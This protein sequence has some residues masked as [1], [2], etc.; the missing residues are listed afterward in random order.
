MLT[1]A[2]HAKV[3]R[4]MR[5]SCRVSHHVRQSHGLQRAL[6]KAT[7]CQQLGLPLKGIRAS[8]HNH[9]QHMMYQLQRPHDLKHSRNLDRH[10]NIYSGRTSASTRST[11]LPDF[12]WS[13]LIWSVF[14]QALEVGFSSWRYIAHRQAV[15]VLAAST[16]LDHQRFRVLS[17]GMEAFVSWAR[18]GFLRRRA[19]TSVPPDWHC[20]SKNPQVEQMQR[21]VRTSFVL[22]LSLLHPFQSRNCP[23]GSWP[24]MPLTHQACLDFQLSQNIETTSTLP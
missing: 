23:P 17:A 11:T 16:V 24:G 14:L 13:V 19:S 20:N 8:S 4:D 22:F 15:L 6:Q 7:E 18:H 9:N 10:H 5:R 3:V 12:A 21:L 1:L 2:S